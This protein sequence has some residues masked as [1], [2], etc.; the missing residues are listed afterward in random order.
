MPPEVQNSLSIEQA[1]NLI[2]EAQR[3][4]TEVTLEVTEKRHLE[5]LEV[6]EKR[7]L[8]TLK[9]VEERHAENLRLHQETQ[10]RLGRIEENTIIIRDRV[11]SQFEGISVQTKNEIE[12]LAEEVLDNR[13]EIL[14]EAEVFNLSNP[15]YKTP[16]FKAKRQEIRGYVLSSVVNGYNNPVDGGDFYVTNEGREVSERGYVSA[17]GNWV[18]N[19]VSQLLGKNLRGKYPRQIRPLIDTLVGFWVLERIENGRLC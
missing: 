7:H 5:T 12:T 10:A 11:L 15:Q 2:L 14:A 16:E 4:S 17:C 9:L 8:E 18:S 3:K 1:L 19:V 6:T 13:E